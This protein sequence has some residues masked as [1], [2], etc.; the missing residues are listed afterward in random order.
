MFYVPFNYDQITMA[1]GRT[2]PSAVKSF[3]NKSFWFWC[4]SLY[5]RMCSVLKIDLPADWRGDIKDFFTWCLFRFGYVC[6]SKN[7]KYGLFFQPCT[8]SGIDFY[9]QPV[10]AIVSNPEYHAELLIGKE[11]EILKLTP[12][13]YSTFDIVEYYAEKLSTLDNAINMSLINSKYSFMWGAKNKAAGQA[14]KK[15]L[16]LIN[17]GEPAVVWDQKLLNDPNDKDIPFQELKRDNLKESYLTTMQLQDWQTIINNF[18]A[19]VGIPSV[20]YQKKERLV[21][22]EANMRSIDAKARSITWIETLDSSLAN[23]KRLYPDAD[24]AFSLRYETAEVNDNEQR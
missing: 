3:N 1:A 9:Y 20:P 15:M 8:I 6:I 4:R 22:D 13:F 17:K 16:D 12:D 10:R 21:T 11:C 19:E 2:S 5:Q 23:V 18:D 7:D 14:L 24:I